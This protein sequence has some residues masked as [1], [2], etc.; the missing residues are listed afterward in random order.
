M[1]SPERGNRRS[2][3][4][5]ISCFWAGLPLNKWPIV[6]MVF[7]E[8][9]LTVFRRNDFLYV[10]HSNEIFLIAFFIVQN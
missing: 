4:G 7:L 2:Q 9:Y 5:L 3:T 10:Y 8:S 1:K 6:K